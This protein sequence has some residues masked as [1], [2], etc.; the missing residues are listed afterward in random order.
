MCHGTGHFYAENA[1]DA[2]HEPHDARDEISP[3]EDGPVPRAATGHARKL[4]G[5]AL[6]HGSSA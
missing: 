2:D 4:G 5:F 1:G 3:R 6:E